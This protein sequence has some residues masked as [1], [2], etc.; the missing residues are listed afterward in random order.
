M[1]E[2][3]PVDVVN[4]KLDD[5]LDAVKQLDTTCDYAK[6]KAKT[7]LMAQD[8]NFC[9][10]RFCFKHGLPEIHGCGEAVKKLERE[11]FLKPVPQKTI[12]KEQDLKKAHA[13]MDQKLK[14]MNLARKAK[15]PKSK[16]KK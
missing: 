7:T 14:D 8:C 5:V 16:P 3:I 11:E 15:P 10:H 2:P 12:K 6:C 4:T 13:R 9:K 1:L